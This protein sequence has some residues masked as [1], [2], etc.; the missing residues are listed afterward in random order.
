MKKISVKDF[1]QMYKTNSK[2]TDKTFE[3][4]IK[5]HIV[6]DYI[7]FIKKEVICTTIINSTCYIES[8]GRQIVKIN[9]PARFIIF[10]M[11]L[12]DL[13]T[14]IEVDFTDANY[15]K[16]YD[17]LN[18]IGAINTLIS[19]IPNNEY[20]EFNT[21]LNMKMDDFRDNEYSIKAFLYNLKESFN[22]SED[23]INSAIKELEKEAEKEN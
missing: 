18:K 14:D 20:V 19:A 2:T 5:K 4:F 22:I 8:G 23:I 13:Y 16:Q 3:D 6:V 12:I 10:I 17:E 1:V 7:D 9:S 15:V 11:R 21:M